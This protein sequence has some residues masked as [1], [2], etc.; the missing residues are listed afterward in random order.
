MIK[1]AADSVG[2]LSMKFVIAAVVLTC[3]VL[4]LIGLILPIVPGLLF[5]V[6]A[7]VLVTRYFPAIDG[8]LRRNGTLARHLDGADRLGR[9]DLWDQIRVGGLICARVVLEAFEAIGWVAGRLLDIAGD[10]LRRSR[11]SR[12]RQP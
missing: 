3:V 12:R 9:L 8:W 1:S 4:G 5:L 6:V 11:S 2:K 7:A 10:A